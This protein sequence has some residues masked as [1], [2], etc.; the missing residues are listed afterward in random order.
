MQAAW[1]VCQRKINPV[2][3]IVFLTDGH[4]YGGNTANALSI[5]EQIANQGIATM[6]TMGI[7]DNFNFDLMRQFSAPSGGM[8][9]N[10]VNPSDA[11]NVFRQ[12]LRSS[13]QTLA[14]SLQLQ[15]LF[16]PNVR[17]VEIYQS[18]PEK[19]SMN[20]HS[21]TSAQ[22]TFY[23]LFA[24]DLAASAPKQFAIRCRAD[25]PNSSFTR[26]ADIS[27]SY[28]IPQ[29]GEVKTM[30][31]QWNLNLAPDETQK[32][33][34]SF[35]EDC[36]REIELLIGLEQALRLYEKKHVS[37]ALRK[38]SGLIADAKNLG[39]VEQEKMLQNSYDKIL[40]NENL[41]QA[42]LNRMLHRS[43]RASRVRVQAK[44]KTTKL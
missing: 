19:R 42:D 32:R 8:T 1:T 31:I 3:K 2:A 15:L 26:L 4:P 12:I 44:P 34:D 36:F 29:T 38:L 5:S 6:D 21:T 11:R 9:E 43:S 27:L 33:H 7:G 30:E 13:Q 18:A 17:D 14:S 22:G 39:D 20:A 23:Q 16:S 37:E 24:G 41:T 35:V 40:R 10:L 28:R 25:L